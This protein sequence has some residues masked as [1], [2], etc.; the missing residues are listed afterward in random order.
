[1]LPTNTVILLELRYYHR[2]WV[3]CDT[4]KGFGGFLKV[5]PPDIKR[6][7]EP[8]FIGSI[9][10]LSGLLPTRNRQ[11]VPVKRGVGIY[12]LF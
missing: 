6:S 11:S 9:S 2:A 5:C 1:M 10:N 7:R 4:N 12:L 8:L 3:T